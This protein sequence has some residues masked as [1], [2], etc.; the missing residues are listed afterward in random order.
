MSTTYPLR[1][2]AFSTF[3]PGDVAWLL[4]DYSTLPLEAD[5]TVR[6]AAIQAGVA[7]YADSLPVEY[8]PTPAYLEAY[9]DSV[10]RNADLVG[11]CGARVAADIWAAVGPD[12]VLVS[13]ARAG[14]VA[15][16]MLRQ[17]AARYYGADWAHYAISIVRD[18]GIDLSALQW[19]TE[20]VDPSN[21]VFV[22]AWTG[23]GAIRSE[24]SQAL[25]GTGFPDR[26]VVLADPAGVADFAGVRE[27]VLVPSACLN[28]TVSGLVSR[29]VLP[30]PGRNSRHGA[31]FYKELADVDQSRDLVKALVSGA[32]SGPVAGAGQRELTWSGMSS[33]ERLQA[34]FG[35]PSLHLVKPGLGETT[36][37]LLRR[38]PWKVLVSQGHGGS[39]AL[40]HIR[41]LADE[42]GVPVVE[43][44]T[45]PYLAIGL[46]RP[47]DSSDV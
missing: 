19:L 43:A 44:D 16:I 17:L 29:T 9:R 45:G 39:S 18:R 40:T 47:T 38:V 7:H 13:L 28:A 46:V 30:Q 23:K 41:Q 5:V 35:L 27:D 22:D 32:P 6:E 20:H 15:G 4:E 3:E 37:V 33:V 24:L 34:E 10:S 2:P 25:A 21:V 26:L 31:K 12:A 14:V 1:G 8:E 42:R 11:L 36:R